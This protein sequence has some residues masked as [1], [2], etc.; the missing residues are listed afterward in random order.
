MSLH[1]NT[2]ITSGTAVP[3][4]VS[5]VQLA[6]QGFMT[7]IC[8]RGPLTPVLSQSFAEWESNHGDEDLATG[9]ARVAA[10]TFFRTGGQ[11]LWTSR[12]TGPAPVNATVNLF[13]QSGS[14]NPGDVSLVVTAVNPGEW[15]N[16]AADGL[17]VEVE[18]SGVT[19]GSFVL[20]V[21]LAGDEVDRSPELLNSAAA[22]TWA[23]T[24]DWIRIAL[25]ASAED[26]RD[27]A[28]VSNLAT[29]ADDVANVTEA[30]WTAAL[31]KF[32]MAL[33]PGSVFAPGRTTAA[34]HTALDEHG[35]AFDRIPRKDI[36]NTATIATIT[37]AAATQRALDTA[38]EGGFFGP[39]AIVPGDVAGTTRTVPYSAVAA[40]VYARNLATGMPIGQASAGVT[41]GRPGSWVLGL[42]VNDSE[43]PTTTA[44]DDDDLDALHQAGVNVAYR[45]DDEITLMGYRTVVDEAEHDEYVDLAGMEL[46]S[47]VNSRVRG[48]LRR[49]QF[50]SMDKKRQYFARIEEQVIGEL[51]PLF[52]TGRLYGDTPEEAFRVDAGPSVNTDATIAARK[53]GVDYALKTSPTAEQMIGRSI[54]VATG[55]T[56]A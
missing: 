19:A 9:H 2:T 30:Q 52:L 48:I 54:K 42:A 13:D 33:G 36:A 23:A 44:W 3:N 56:L 17:S 55:G 31:A 35:K 53:A 5:L 15:A 43:D 21:R 28:G 8:Q 50:G 7:A 34:A 26:P 20:I 38:K 49:A 24:S 47:L 46:L 6:G 11:R 22:V 39:W 41:Y 40:G 4:P 16:G 12:V 18:T 29:G 14:T 37:A 51:Q 1:P 45:E 25:G 27:T 32:T 10:E